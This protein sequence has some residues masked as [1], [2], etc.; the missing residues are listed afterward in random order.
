MPS[1]DNCNGCGKYPCE[2]VV[3]DSGPDYSAPLKSK[4]FVAETL[5]QAMAQAAE[6][7]QRVA[8]VEREHVMDVI[9]KTVTGEGKTREKAS[10]SARAR[11]P[12]NAFN[13]GA[14]ELLREGQSGVLEVTG[15]SRRA[16]RKRWSNNG[17]SEAKLDGLRC[18]K[19]PGG[20]LW[21]S[22]TE[23]TWE[24]RW[25]TPCRVCISYVTPAEVTI[26]YR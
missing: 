22:R 19:R 25:S 16:A 4:V 26:W 20:F 12:F 11:L 10:D 18:I 1:Y 15:F 24:A 13:V 2:C 9:H 8:E 17:P 5:D 14:A 6:F 3:D 7:K 23:G 21:F